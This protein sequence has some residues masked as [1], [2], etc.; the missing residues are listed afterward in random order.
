M[1]FTFS[2]PVIAKARSIRS[3]KDRIAVGTVDTDI[4]VMEYAKPDVETAFE[5]QGKETILTFGGKLWRKSY[6]NITKLSKDGFCVLAEIMGH[7]DILPILE[8]FNE[9]CLEAVKNTPRGGLMPRVSAKYDFFTGDAPLKYLETAGP[10]SNRSV[11]HVDEADVELW[12]DRMRSYLANYALVDGQ[13]YERCHEPV[14][15][16]NQNGR[17]SLN[18][19]IL[20]GRYV[21]QLN[22]YS[23]IESAA[24]AINPAYVIST[25]H[26]FPADM[27]DEAVE[28][29]DSITTDSKLAGADMFSIVCHGKCTT[30]PDILDLETCRFAVAHLDYFKSV[31]D[32]FRGFYGF[33]EHEQE[34][35]RKDSKL[36]IYAKE[37][38]TVRE[39][40]FK[41]LNETPCIEEL[42]FALSNLVAA[43]EQVDKPDMLAWE[44]L[45]LNTHRL[46]SRLEAAPITLEISTIPSP[47]IG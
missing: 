18:K 24:V 7:N 4:D 6:L 31:N 43:G 45:I 11:S 17:I 25:V 2:H 16:V 5:I 19:F 14:L 3:G 33:T 10:L 34:L 47:R 42:S 28:F 1:L 38:Q 21:G 32:K 35:L 27:E 44:P 12:R 41:H 36:S 15:L 9:K 37:A 30:L 20:Y 40:I 13:V 39:A 8:T 46:F 22:F 29:A 23:S 26:V